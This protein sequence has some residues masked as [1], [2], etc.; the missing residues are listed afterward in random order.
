MIAFSGA[1][2]ADAAIEVAASTV[3]RE[4]HRNGMVRGNYCYVAAQCHWESREW[5][6]LRI[7]PEL[8]Q[9]VEIMLLEGQWSPEQISATFA[10]TAVSQISHETIYQ[11]IYR[12]KRAGGELHKHLRHRCKSYRQ[13]ASGRER[14]GRIKNQVMINQRPPIVDECCRIGDWEMDTVIGRLDG[15]VLVTMV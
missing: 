3:S 6:G 5:K 10:K 8:W 2:Q 4:L 13:R 11:H 9:Q 7:A 14:R 1:Q 15:K 12:D